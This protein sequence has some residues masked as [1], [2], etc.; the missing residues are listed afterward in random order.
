MKGAS[1]EDGLGNGEQGE[2]Q[3]NEAESREMRV[4]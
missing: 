1:L 3:R 4:Q 2:A